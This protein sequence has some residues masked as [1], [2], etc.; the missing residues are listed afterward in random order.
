MICLGVG[1]AEKP[2][3]VERYCR[4]R[5]INR[6]VVVT[7]T[8]RFPWHGESTEVVDFADTIKY[9]VFYRLLQEVDKNTL[10]VLN[11]CL[12]TQ[13]RWH[14]QFRNR[15]QKEKWRIVSS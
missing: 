3:L 14:S 4:G 15:L 6:V 13:D 2:A 7:P 1:A 5:G 10:I 12:R 8:K 11:E 9:V